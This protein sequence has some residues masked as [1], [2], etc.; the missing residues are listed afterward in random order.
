MLKDA[1]GRPDPGCAL[2]PSRDVRPVM[3]AGLKPEQTFPRYLFEMTRE[4][5]P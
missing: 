2:H 1:R 5:F 3:Q 4:G